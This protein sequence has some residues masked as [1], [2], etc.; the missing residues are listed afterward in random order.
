MEYLTLEGAGLEVSELC[1]GTW[2]FGME[3]DGVVETD[4]ETAHELLDAALDRGINFIDTSNNYGTPN[5]TSERYIGDWLADRD[6]EDFVVASKVFAPMGDGPN[7]GGLSRKHIRSQI[8][9]TLERLGTDYIDI[10]YLHRWDDGTPIEETLSTL[11]GLVKEGKV[12]YIG[13]STMAAWKLMKGLGTS[14]LHDFERFTVAQPLFHAAY[15]DDIADYLDVCAEHDLTVCPYS[16]LAGGFLTGKYQKVN[17]NE[18]E[19]EGPE[20]SRGDIYSLFGDYYVSDRGWHV[21]EAVESV[22]DELDAS[23]AQVALRWLMQYDRCTTVPIIGARTVTQLDENVGATEI[24]LTND[25]YERIVDA[26]Y[27]EDGKRWGHR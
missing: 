11:D 13:A 1:L 7:T 18:K 12:H 25:Q 24:T 19:F 3:S 26:R 14:E 4:R 16:P 23:P 10:Y 9:E 6:R 17:E 2:R 27:A 22:A 15:R 5:G 20:G 8:D 21:L